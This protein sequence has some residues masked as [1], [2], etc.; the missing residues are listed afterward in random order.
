MPGLAGMP[1]LTKVLVLEG[2]AGS[3]EDAGSE[4]ADSADEASSGAEA[5]VCAHGLGHAC[6]LGMHRLYDLGSTCIDGG[7]CCKIGR[8]LGPK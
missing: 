6:G 4:N 5:A 2:D 8:Y 1:V 7:I 3:D